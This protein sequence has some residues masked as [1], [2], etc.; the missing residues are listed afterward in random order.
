[1]KNYNAKNI[2]DI[3][4]E[5]PINYYKRPFSQN[6]NRRA[7]WATVEGVDA[8]NEK[9]NQLKNAGI[10]IKCIYNG[11]GEIIKL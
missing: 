6:S 9:V 8:L 7:R 11:I 2:Y 4:Y 5:G 1:M 10:V 3:F